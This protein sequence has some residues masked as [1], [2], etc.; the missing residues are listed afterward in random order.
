MT[1]EEVKTLSLREKLQIMDAIWMDLR[2]H[3]ETLDIPQSHKELLD[4]RRERVATGKAVLHDWD[5][6]KDTIGRR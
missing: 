3:V 6:V 1:L 2:E 5:D 4:V